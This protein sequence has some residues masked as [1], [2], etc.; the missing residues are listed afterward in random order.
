MGRIGGIVIVALI[1]AAEVLHTGCKKKDNPYPYA[2]SRL[3]KDTLQGTWLFHYHYEHFDAAGGLLWDKFYDTSMTI[4]ALSDSTVKFRSGL[5][6]YSDSFH[7][8][9][10]GGYLINTDSFVHYWHK[11]SSFNLVFNRTNDS[12]YIKIDEDPGALGSQTLG[13]YSTLIKH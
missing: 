6:T 4:S 10:G 7:Y 5:L 9:F 12:L 1:I 8:T 13:T 2:L 3:Y 11:G